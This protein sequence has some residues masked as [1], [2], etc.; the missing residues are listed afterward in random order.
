VTRWKCLGSVLLLCV[1]SIL[2]SAEPKPV[3]EIK[4]PGASAGNTVVTR[5]LVYSSD[6]LFLFQLERAQQPKLRE[7]N[8]ESSYKLWIYPYES[9][10][11]TPLP[12]TSYLAFSELDEL[13]PLAGTLFVVRLDQR[14]AV[15]SAEARILFVRNLSELKDRDASI[16]VRVPPDARSFYI[17]YRNRRSDPLRIEQFDAASH[18]RILALQLEGFPDP[19][20]VSNSAFIYR[21]RNVKNGAFDL[22]IQSRSDAQPRLLYRFKTNQCLPTAGFVTETQVA[23]LN[24]EKLQIIDL[25][26]Q[27][28]FAKKIGDPGALMITTASADRKRTLL[29][30]INTEP[31]RYVFGPLFGDVKGQRI[32]IWDE[33]TR[34]I[35]FHLPLGREHERQPNFA[36]APAGDQLAIIESDTI[37]I[38]PVKP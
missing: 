30:V 37:R 9:A 13:F 18:K 22:Q 16:A 11:G 33:P 6:K 14:V 20:A 29:Q 32:L 12:P 2:S 4:A 36:F 5:R 17:F 21:L 35:A 10:T 1:A 15:M 7:R 31:I 24:C 27:E 8:K 34:S 19:I 25:N 26:G 28:I 23:V 38:Y 3:R